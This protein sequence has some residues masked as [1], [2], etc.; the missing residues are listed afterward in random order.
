[1]QALG[2]E[3]V[4]G[5]EVVQRLKD[6][7][8]GAYLVGQRRQRQL[9]PLTGI[10]LRLPVQRLVLSELVE[11]DHRQE[12]GA[13]EPS[14]GRVERCRRLADPFAV[15]AGELLAYR[16]DHRKPAVKTALCG[17]G[18]RLENRAYGQSYAQSL[19]AA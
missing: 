19:R 1:M 4:G 11:Q 18:I 8:A 10:A 16:L 6:M 13:E 9:D 12:V 14:R 15:P 17:A 7:S 3:D 2:G 5:N